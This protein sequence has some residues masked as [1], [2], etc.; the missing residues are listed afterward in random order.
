MCL[1]DT[2]SEEWRPVVGFEG[3]YEVSNL[4]RVRRLTGGRNTKAGKILK[5]QNNSRGYFTVRL[6]SNRQDSR[7]YTI[8]AL[9]A[10]AFIGPRPAG[11]DVDHR[12]GV[13]INNAAVNLEWVTRAENIRRAYQ[14]HGVW[15]ET[16]G[17]ANGRARLTAADVLAIRAMEGQ[18]SASDVAA[19]FRVE[20]S[21]VWKIWARTTWGHL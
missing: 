18:R 21:R 13:R 3:R 19:E 8:H 15:T 11:Y 9:V 4:G 10:T 2:P 16:K 5:P 20:K 17:E 14:R 6:G 12:D 1:D 7:D